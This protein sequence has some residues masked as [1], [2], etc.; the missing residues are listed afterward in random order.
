[1]I[2][3][4][5]FNHKINIRKYNIL[6][7][8]FMS[9]R[10]NF[11]SMKFQKENRIYNYIKKFRTGRDVKIDEEEMNRIKESMPQLIEYCKKNGLF[12]IK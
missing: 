7:E 4:L 9:F 5:T 1:M 12:L 10:N 3:R 11:S 8:K 6:K 2:I